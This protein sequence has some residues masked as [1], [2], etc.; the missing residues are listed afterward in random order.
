M[1]GKRFKRIVSVLLIL[2]LMLGLSGCTKHLPS[3]K[4]VL[5]G[6]IKNI[7]DTKEGTM[8]EFQIVREIDTA[9]L[10]YTEY[11][12][13]LRDDVNGGLLAKMMTPTDQYLT[14]PLADDPQFPTTTICNN[15]NK[16]NADE[17]CQILVD[18]D[19]VT[20]M[21]FCD[22]VL[23]TKPNYEAP[24]L[25]EL[26]PYKVSS[27]EK[28]D[29]FGYQSELNYMSFQ[30]LSSKH[31]EL[32]YTIGDSL[33]FKNFNVSVMP[34]EGAYDRGIYAYVLQMGKDSEKK[35]LLIKTPN[36]Y[37]V[38]LTQDDGSYSVC[39]GDIEWI[40]NSEFAC[41]VD[42]YSMGFSSSL[43]L[44]VGYTVYEQTE[45]FDPF[46][47][48]IPMTITDSEQGGWMVGY[49]TNDLLYDPEANLGNGC[50]AYAGEGFVSYY[51][52]YAFDDETNTIYE[53]DPGRLYVNPSFG[54]V[55]YDA[56]L[57]VIT[58]AYIEFT[59]MK[60]GWLETWHEDWKETPM[61]LYYV[62]GEGPVEN[63]EQ[64]KSM[65]IYDVVMGFM[66]DPTESGV[67]DLNY[68]YVKFYPSMILGRYVSYGPMDYD[69][70]YQVGEDLKY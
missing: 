17:V 5:Y 40:S 11:S 28:L 32:N 20:R 3:G 62:E 13:A 36:Y 65:D 52:R 57:N 59:P 2:V 26:N 4:R 6:M 7:T 19:E 41:Y 27:L 51:R 66:V 25:G 54:V 12:H 15:W 18:A 21:A 24:I 64:C 10:G 35:Q 42:L 55:Y 49:H 56:D 9:S 23:W 14:L 63:M 1:N 30:E 29:L 47:S 45:E 44:S 33:N 58:P 46:S 37:N 70:I 68:R 31:Y 69:N 67:E 50:C 16:N 53:V 22:A 34:S 8:V 39:Y 43:N 48:S 61:K 38:F 60:E